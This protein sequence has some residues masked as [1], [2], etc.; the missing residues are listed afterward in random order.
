MN[1]SNKNVFIKKKRKGKFK[2]T[3]SS[4]RPVSSDSLLNSFRV[5]ILDLSGLISVWRLFGRI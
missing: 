5:D 2:Q 3:N 1:I 4:A